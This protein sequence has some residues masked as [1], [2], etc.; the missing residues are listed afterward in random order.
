MKKNTLRSNFISRRKKLLNTEVQSFSA[1]ITKRV[2]NLPIGH[3]DCFH[4]FLS[5]D[6]NHEVNT[7]LII[8]FLRKENKTVV[9]PKVSGDILE[10]FIYSPEDTLVLNKWGIP[11]PVQ[12]K[13]VNTQLLDVVFVPL[14]AFDEKGNRVGYGK[15][16]YD[17][18]LEECKNDVL[19]VGLSFFDPIESIDDI[20]PHDIP[21]DYCVTPNKI[22]SF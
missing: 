11:E 21:L 13:Q 15:G 7:T 22:Y 6:R 1:S 12:G 14:L 3:H 8:D 4:V 16:F 5:I 9:V 19:K 2:Q 17:R 10:H 20:G 18:F